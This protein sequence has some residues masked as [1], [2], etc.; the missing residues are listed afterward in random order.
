VVRLAVQKRNSYD[1]CFTQLRE[2]SGLRKRYPQQFEE[3]KVLGRIEVAIQEKLAILK[4]M[5]SQRLQ[6]PERVSL[7]DFIAFHRQGSSSSLTTSSTITMTSGKEGGVRVP[8]HLLQSS[9]GSPFSPSSS[10]SSIQVDIGK[11][12]NLSSDGFSSTDSNTSSGTSPSSPSIATMGQKVS[13]KDF[14]IIKPI[15]RGAFG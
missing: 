2:F 14:T 6:Q 1:E 4:E 12:L 11:S 9:G 5:L 13:I 10:T 3:S 8:S 7:R 15:S